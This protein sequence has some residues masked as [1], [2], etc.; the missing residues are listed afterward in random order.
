MN[1][2]R[3]FGRVFA[4]L[5][6]VAL[7]VLFLLGTLDLIETDIGE[8]LGWIASI[9][10]VAIG[11]GFL[12]IRRGQNVFFPIV[13][14][15]VGLF[16]ILGNLGVDAYDYWPVIIIL[17]GGAVLFGGR[18]RRR[19]SRSER[20]TIES[21]STSSS[22]MDSEINVSCTLGEAS[23]RVVSDAFTGGTVNVTMGSVNLDLRDSKIGN[24]HA[25]LDVSVTMGELNLR[26]PPEWIVEFDNVVTLGD[27]DDKRARTEPTAGAP[28]LVIDGKLTMGSL[29]IDD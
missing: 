8:I 24:P 11:L 21:S 5:I 14:I 27:A 1:P 25:R 4:G 10:M 22:T 18:R 19:K 16:I 2:K 20:R 23:E 3:G 12:I 13:L 26:V 7:G 15:G 29:T 17:I 9:L 6:L 28:L